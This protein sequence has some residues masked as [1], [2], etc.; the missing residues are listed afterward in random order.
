M[1]SLSA[2]Y[3]FHGVEGYEDARRELFQIVPT[4]G[5]KKYPGAH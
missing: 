3:L 4:A 1:H 5:D 2:L